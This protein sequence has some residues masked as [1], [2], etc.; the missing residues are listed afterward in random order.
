MKEKIR[1]LTNR[2]ITRALEHSPRRLDVLQ[3]SVGLDEEIRLG[4]RSDESRLH[5]GRVLLDDVLTVVGLG[6]LEDGFVGWD[7]GER[8]V[9]GERGRTGLDSFEGGDG[10]VEVYRYET[11]EDEI[12]QRI[13]E[14]RERNIKV[15]KRSPSTPKHL[16][17]AAQWNPW[18]FAC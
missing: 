8:R 5:L 15:E 17:T 9:L 3:L 10:S 6:Y 13:F 4:R 12:S 7:V 11:E 2:L 16:I 18:I 1:G 14:A